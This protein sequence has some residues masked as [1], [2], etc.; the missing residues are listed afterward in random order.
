[1]TLDFV[2][3]LDWPYSHA[4]CKKAF[5]ILTIAIVTRITTVV[6]TLWVFPGLSVRKSGPAAGQVS[7]AISL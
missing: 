6:V 7:Y 2:A 4:H 3:E 5:F 1:V